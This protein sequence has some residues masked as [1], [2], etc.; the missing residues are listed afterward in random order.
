[1]SALFH[2]AFA[3]V[4]HHSAPENG[5]ALVIGAFELQPRIVGIDRAPRKEMADLL[6]PNDHVD[7]NGFAAPQGRLYFIQWRGHRRH[8]TVGVRRDLALRFFSYCKRGG[9]LRL[10]GYAEFRCSLRRRQ[11]KNIDRQGA[12]PE[13][14][15]SQLELRSIFIG[16]RNCGVGARKTMRMHK[17]TNVAGIVRSLQWHVTIR[18]LRRFRRIVKRTRALSRY[19]TGLPI[20]IFVEAAKAAIVIYRHIEM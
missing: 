3:V 10:R 4:F 6:R 7:T 18:T 13:K 19:P 2:R 1:M 16:R 17:S 5:L 14:V 9:K 20:V 8:F 12:I 15:F 11:S